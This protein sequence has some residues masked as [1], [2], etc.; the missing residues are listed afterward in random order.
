MKKILFISLVVFLIN[1]SALSQKQG[2]E[3]T[4]WKENRLKNMSVYEDKSTGLIWQDEKVNK[5]KEITWYKATNY[6]KHLILANSTSWRLPS[7]EELKKLY[8]KKDK[9]RYVTSYYYWTSS[10]TFQDNSSAWIVAFNAGLTS[11]NYKNRYTSYR[12]V[13]AQSSQH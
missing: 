6:C 4:K 7:V 13:R 8:A 2:L 5:T 11:F 3:K 12:C 9:L 1:A 10:S